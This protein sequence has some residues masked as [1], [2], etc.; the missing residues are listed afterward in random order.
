MEKVIEKV[1]LYDLLGY[2]FPGFFMLFILLIDFI[3][4]IPD[5]TINLVKDH[6]GIFV[7]ALIVLSHIVGILLSESGKK[8]HILKGLIQKLPI[9][10]RLSQ[11]IYA[12]KGLSSVSGSAS[13][14]KN[15]IYERALEFVNK[16]DL[17]AALSKSGSSYDLNDER[18][19]DYIYSVIQVN[20]EFSRIHSYASAEVMSR[21]TATACLIGGFLALVLCV[22]RYFQLFDNGY[23]CR[24]QLL[25]MIVLFLC[26]RLM[27]ERSAT[28]SEKKILY[29]CNW[30]ILKYCNQMK[31]NNP[32]AN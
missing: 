7:V 19:A 9:L 31:Q 29:A 15:A 27:Y 12:L 14:N 28:F 13:Q 6:S 26:S 23:R 20:P 22:F 3:N 25:A 30:F 2:G 21:N 1:T 16:E 4:L 5:T 8:M 11:K 17:K 24:F 10:K 32:M 18:T